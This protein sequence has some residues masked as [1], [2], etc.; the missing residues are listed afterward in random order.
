[1]AAI[2]ILR[3]ASDTAIRICVPDRLPSWLTNNKGETKM[4]TDKYTKFI[5]TAIAI[6]LF[7][8]AGVDIIKP[9]KADDGYIINRILVCID[10]STMRE[11]SLF[12]GY[13]LSTT[14]TN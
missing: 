8:N 9:A 3:L 11:N 5:L 4:K 13:R 2:T 1:M 7:A 14:C 10:G 6:G 12:G